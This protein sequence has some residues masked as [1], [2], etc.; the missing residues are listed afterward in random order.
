MVS[1][2]VYSSWL[3]FLPNSQFHSQLKKPFSSPR[4]MHCASA[5]SRAPSSSALRICSSV[6]SMVPSGVRP[7]R[8][9]SAASV[10]SGGAC[11]SCAASSGVSCCRITGLFSCAV[12][13]VSVLSVVS[14]SASSARPGTSGSGSS[15]VSC[16]GSAGFS[17]AAGSSP[18]SAVVSDSAVCAAGCSAASDCACAVGPSAV[19]GSSVLSA[20]HFSEEAADPVCFFP[21]SFV[22]CSGSVPLCC[23]TMGCTVTTPCRSARFMAAPRPP[24]ASTIAMVKTAAAL[25][26][27]RA[28]DLL[29]QIRFM[30]Y[31]FASGSLFWL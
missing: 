6:N 18:C 26:Q 31:F 13:A 8:S 27:P 14:G 28:E 5:S 25:P 16:A 4:S 12:S 29:F 7:D 21:K 17:A 19:R 10:S 22:F 2:P 23:R 1:Q 30:P 20:A 24:T 15:A 3:S 11:G 9:F